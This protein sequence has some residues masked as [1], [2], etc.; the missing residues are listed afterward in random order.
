MQNLLQC[1][2]C[3]SFSNDNENT[4]HEPDAFNPEWYIQTPA[5]QINITANSVNL[6]LWPDLVYMVIVCIVLFNQE[7]TILLVG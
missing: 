4:A 5:Q 3:L 1:I 2:T 7:A 6:K